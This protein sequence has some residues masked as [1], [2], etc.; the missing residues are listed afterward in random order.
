MGEANPN[1]KY[2]NIYIYCFLHTHQI[3]RRRDTD[4]NER[5]AEVVR[6]GDGLRRDEP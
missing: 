3:M 1:P 6:F 5:F 4:T 2:T